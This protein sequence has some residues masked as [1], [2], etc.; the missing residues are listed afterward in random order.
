[1]GSKIGNQSNHRRES[2][3]DCQDSDDV[4]DMVT[5]ANPTPRMVPE[6]LAGQPMQSQLHL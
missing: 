4:Y 3:T 6:F 2:S 5:G 1:M